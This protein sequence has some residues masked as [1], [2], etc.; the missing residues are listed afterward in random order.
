MTIA[1]AAAARANSGPELVERYRQVRA[2]RALE[3]A[4]SISITPEERVAW[5]GEDGGASRVIVRGDG[6]VL[7]RVG[8]PDALALDCSSPGDLVACDDGL[9]LVACAGEL[10][11]FDGEGRKGRR[12][13]L[14]GQ[15]EGLG[16]AGE[17]LRV[18]LRDGDGRLRTY[19]HTGADALVPEQGELAPSAWTDDG[20][21]DGGAADLFGARIEG[22]A[23]FV[24]RAGAL[25]GGKGAAVH[26][27]GV[28]GV[29]TATVRAAVGC[30]R[31]FVQYTRTEVEGAEPWGLAA[32]S[33]PAWAMVDWDGL[34]TERD[35]PAAIREIWPLPQG[36][37][38][39]A[40]FLTSSG[41]LGLVPVVDAIVRELAPT[42]FAVG[43]TAAAVA[44]GTD[45]L[46]AIRTYSI[47]DRWLVVRDRGA[48]DGV[49][50]PSRVV[51][52]RRGTL[53]AVEGAQTVRLWRRAEQ[54]VEP[55]IPT[56]RAVA[57]A[58]GVRLD[59]T[60]E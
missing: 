8:T 58:V 53:V 25:Q 35:L 38:A 55:T 3:P 28:D 43:V 60:V 45:D 21:C 17:R 6:L 19:A 41:Q 2:H 5:L 47:E 40:L 24:V 26:R 15:V 7:R 32:V 4:G 36:S 34:V 37:G 44:P 12:V 27:S 59:E 52:D 29:V 51:L 22:G 10:A 11:T 50:E 54:A 48:V 33:P 49:A 13:A 1:Q 39:Y 14:A 46:H 42:I 16:C 23:L 57:D 18:L 20:L 9:P 56:P 30:D 31:F